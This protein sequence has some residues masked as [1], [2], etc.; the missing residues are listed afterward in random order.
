[1]GSRR[2]SRGLTLVEMLIV[3]AMVGVL[4]TLA[5]VAY[6]RWVRS[7]F[8]VEGQ[9]MV[10]GIRTAEERFISENG[11][12]LDVTK[13]VGAGCTYPLQNPTN[14]KTAWGGPCSW[15]TNPKVAFGGLGV[16]PNGP[17]VFGYS[18]IA[19]QAASPG[20]RVGSKT[21]NGATLDLSAMNNGAPWYFIEADANI[22][23]DQVN[24]T[25]I[26]GMSGT[27]TIFIDGEGN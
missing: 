26:Y 23:G 17:V 4:A 19:D 2:H 14:A 16:S 6:R 1:M 21:V 9:D 22:S 18:V 13:C 11:A 10:A 25:H 27:N 15:C 20:T 3:V 7:S 5:V 8:I 24:Y 12:Y